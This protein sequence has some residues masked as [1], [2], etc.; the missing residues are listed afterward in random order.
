MPYTMDNFQVDY[1][2]ELFKDMT[3]PAQVVYLMASKPTVRRRIIADMSPTRRRRL[4]KAI[5]TGEYRKI[6]EELFAE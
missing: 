1:A 3:V 5:L 2:K 4:R 6:V